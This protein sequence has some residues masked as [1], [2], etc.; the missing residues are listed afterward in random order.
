MNNQFDELTKSLA[1]S[2]TRRAALKKFS[3]GLTGMALACLGL[4]NKAEG[5]PRPCNASGLACMNNHDC[6]GG[7]CLKGA[8]GSRGVCL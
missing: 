6:C 3:I 4:A 1:Q 2:V 5:R 7:V 8:E